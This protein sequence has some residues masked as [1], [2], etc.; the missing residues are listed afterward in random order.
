M[1]QRGEPGIGEQCPVPVSGQGRLSPICGPRLGSQGAATIWGMAAGAGV[2]GTA[3]SV[4]RLGKRLEMRCCDM[5]PPS[6]AKMLG[7]SRNGS[8]GTVRRLAAASTLT[9]RLLA[10]VRGQGYY[11]SVGCCVCLDTP[12][13]ASCQG[14][15]RL[16]WHVGSTAPP[17]NRGD[18]WSVAGPSGDTPRLGRAE[19]VGSTWLSRDMAEMGTRRGVPFLI[20]TSKFRLLWRLG[21][22]FSTSARTAPAG[23]P[24]GSRCH[25]GLLTWHGSQ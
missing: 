6:S 24:I 14:S 20:N 10:A 5:D 9:R 19:D 7:W 23:S 21:H 17:V 11:S 12:L 25:H 15:G 8:G 2:G 4:T 22:C 13:V 1:N 18:S 3:Y 16:V